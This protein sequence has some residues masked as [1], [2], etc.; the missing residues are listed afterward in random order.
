MFVNCEIENSQDGYWD[1]D[2]SGAYRQ[3]AIITVKRGQIL[4]IQ[5]GTLSKSQDVVN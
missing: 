1:T 5:E 4:I 2:G 3:D